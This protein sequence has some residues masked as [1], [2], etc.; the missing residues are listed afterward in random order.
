MT[1]KIPRELNAPKPNSFDMSECQHMKLICKKE[2]F[3]KLMHIF[4][5]KRVCFLKIRI[6]GNL[7]HC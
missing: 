6:H 3:L 5:G 1:N 2:T 4:K 7:N